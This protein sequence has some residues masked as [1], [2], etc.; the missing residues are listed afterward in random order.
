[1]KAALG[2]Q[3]RDHPE[4]AQLQQ[5]TQYTQV[6]ELALRSTAEFAWQCA[7]N[8]AD[9]PLTSHRAEGHKQKSHIFVMSISVVSL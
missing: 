6:Y 7:Q 2:I 5:P 9:H 1:M 3:M 4:D 8:W